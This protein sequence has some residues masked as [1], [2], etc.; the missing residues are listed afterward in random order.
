MIAGGSR[1][2]QRACLILGYNCWQAAS[3]QPLIQSLAFPYIL[4]AVETETGCHYEINRKTD[5]IAADWLDR[6]QRMF[7]GSVTSVWQRSG[8]VNGRR[9]GD[10]TGR[11]EIQ[12][13]RVLGL[14]VTDLS[15]QS[16]CREWASR[17]ICE[18]GR[19]YRAGH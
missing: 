13:L 15:T 12:V 18:P 8:R 16:A 1:R 11:A 7:R 3:G 19:V 14:V 5:R 2:L 6:A 17:D 9:G 4:T 10:G